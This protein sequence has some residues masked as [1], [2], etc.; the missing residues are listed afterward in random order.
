MARSEISVR[1][2]TASDA[3]EVLLNTAEWLKREGRPLW[4][5]AELS[6]TSLSARYNGAVIVGAFA[7]TQPIGIVFLGWSDPFMWPDVEIGSSGFIHK[8][9]VVEEYRGKGV[10]DLIIE[11]VVDRCKRAGMTHLRLDCAADRPGL[12]AFYRTR[13]FTQT[14][15]RVVGRFDTAFFDKALS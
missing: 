6:P 5:P 7:R 8:L 15:R 3:S 4:I 14:D 13:D 10:A 2:G 12:I 11:D 1:E 9:A